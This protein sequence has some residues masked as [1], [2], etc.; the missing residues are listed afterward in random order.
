MAS[1]H[2]PAVYQRKQCAVPV[3]VDSLRQMCALIFAADRLNYACY[4]PLYH[5]QL[6]QLMTDHPDA[7]ELLVNNGI[8]VSQSNV[9][10]CRNAIDITIE[11]TINW[12]AKTTGRI[13]GFSRNIN[14]YYRW[15]L[16]RHERVLFLEA[17]RLRF[18]KVLSVYRL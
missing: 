5:T 14:A 2:T 8:S 15:C 16:T 6:S 1:V 10:A 4:L 18:Q 12:S 11:Q 3:Y 13:I 7:Y 17:T 9:A